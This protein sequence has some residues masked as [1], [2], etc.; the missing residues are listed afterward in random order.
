MYLSQIPNNLQRQLQQANP[1]L[2]LNRPHNIGLQHQ[3]AGL[4]QQVGIFQQVN[5]QLN[6]N[7]PHHIGLQQQKGMNEH[8]WPP[9]DQFGIALQDQQPGIGQQDGVFQQVN[10][11]LNLNPPHHIGLQNHQAG[12]GQ[13]VGIFQQV[14]PQ[15]NLNPPHHIGLQKQEGMNEHG[16]PPNDQ[17]GIA[18][19][20][21][22]PGIGQ[23]DGVFQQV[24]P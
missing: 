13:Q 15:L 4:G 7:P 2:N 1:Q 23:Q 20:D 16:W 8:G 5:T 14:N 19:Q 12:L 24:N 6:L 11:Q 22:Q 18:L 10:P 3:Q 9:N 21:Q 17:F